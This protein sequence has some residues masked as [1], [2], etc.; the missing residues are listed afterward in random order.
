MIFIAYLYTILAIFKH[1]MH[2]NLYNYWRETEPADVT[3]KI[4]TVF[5]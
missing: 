4:V 5:S 3:F 1:L 2:H